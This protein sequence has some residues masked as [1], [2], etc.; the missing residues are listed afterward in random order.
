MSVAELFGMV[1]FP[2]L[3]SLYWL[4]RIFRLLEKIAKNTEKEGEQK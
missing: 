4:I 3:L 1:F 2:L